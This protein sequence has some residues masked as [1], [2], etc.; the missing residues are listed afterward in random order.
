MLTRGRHVLVVHHNPWAG[1]QQN[2]NNSGD[3]GGR[4]GE[5]EKR[6]GKKRR[7]NVGRK[8]IIRYW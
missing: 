8:D 2:I 4:L 6:R 7:R 1:E 5:D 3:T